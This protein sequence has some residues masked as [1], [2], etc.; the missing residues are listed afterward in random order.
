MRG[1]FKTF[2]ILA[3]LCLVGG[4]PLGF[5]LFFGTGPGDQVDILIP[6]GSSLGQVATNLHTHEVISYPKTFKYLMTFT[7][8]ASRVRAG[9][10][11]FKRGMSLVDALRTLYSSEPIVHQVTF[12]EGW[13]VRQMAAELAKEKLIDEQKFLKYALSP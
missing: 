2:F 6:R 4:L 12:P 3:V 9:E 13:T 10:F 8:G 5:F 7:E 11:R 1:L